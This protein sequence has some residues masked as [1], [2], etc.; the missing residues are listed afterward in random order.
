MADSLVE[1]LDPFDEYT[2]SHYSLDNYFPTHGS[3]SRAAVNLYSAFI[4]NRI[5]R[6]KLSSRE[7]QVYLMTAY[8]ICLKFW[9]DVNDVMGLNTLMANSTRD[10]IS[11]KEFFR[12]EWDMLITLDLR[13]REYTEEALK[14]DAP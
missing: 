9:V 14:F 12:A 4:N 7:S 8:S 5:S 13:I 1:W 3:M 2:R 10:K 6:S 11:K